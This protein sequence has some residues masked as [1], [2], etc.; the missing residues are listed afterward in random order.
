MAREMFCAV[1]IL[2]GVGGEGCFLRYQEMK[3]WICC[4][5]KSPMGSSQ[6]LSLGIILFM[7]SLYVVYLVF[8]K[9]F[10]F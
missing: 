6:I 2:G 1:N 4:R 8:I 9:I 5:L 10:L 7:Q 3:R